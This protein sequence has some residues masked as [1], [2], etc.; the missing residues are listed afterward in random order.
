MKP[1]QYQKGKGGI[2]YGKPL[3]TKFRNEEV[4]P[5]NK[6]KSILMKDII[7]KDIIVQRGGTGM[8]ITVNG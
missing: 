1:N 7:A 8:D 2:I 4:A 5:L 3:N 6:L